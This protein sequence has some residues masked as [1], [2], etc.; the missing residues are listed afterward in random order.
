MDPTKL[1]A[2]SQRLIELS[3]HTKD[4]ALKQKYTEEAFKL[5]FKVEALERDAKAMPSR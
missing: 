5:A 1:R 3:D 2:E 4:G